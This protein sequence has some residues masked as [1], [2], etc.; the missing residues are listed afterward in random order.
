MN[1]LLQRQVISYL[2]RHWE[3]HATNSV[4]KIDM[5]KFLVIHYICVCL[6]SVFVALKI[7]LLSC[8]PDIRTSL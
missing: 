7:E 3:R 4:R 8:L 5:S 2:K 6:S 1:L